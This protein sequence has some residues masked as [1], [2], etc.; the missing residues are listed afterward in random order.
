MPPMFKLFVDKHEEHTVPYVRGNNPQHDRYMRD[1]NEDRCH[2]CDVPKRPKRCV[3]CPVRL[4]K[5]MIVY[6]E[7]YL[8][9][10]AHRR[11]D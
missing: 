7:P 6:V 8:P 2:R 11:Q 3:K 10:P 4:M 5:Q 9:R 1:F